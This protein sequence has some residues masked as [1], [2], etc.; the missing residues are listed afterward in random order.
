MSAKGVFGC[1]PQTGG[2]PCGRCQPGTHGVSCLCDPPQHEAGPVNPAGPSDHGSNPGGSDAGSQH[3]SS[4]EAQS[5]SD[6]SKTTKVEG[7]C[8]RYGRASVGEKMCQYLHPATN[9]WR[10]CMDRDVCPN[11]DNPTRCTCRVLK[12]D[13]APSKGKKR[14]QDGGSGGNSNKKPKVVNPVPVHH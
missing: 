7:F 10:L 5:P 12:S 13:L 14:Q 8:L 2:E 4:P 9:R 1:I 11:P 6:A 3:V